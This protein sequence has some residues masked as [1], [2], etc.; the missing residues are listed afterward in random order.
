[1]DQR[2]NPEQ[3]DLARQLPSDVYYQLIHTLCAS[4]PLVSDAPDGIVSRDN[5]AIA[6]VAALQPAN[7]DE[8]NLAAT[9]VAAHA[10][11]MN[12]LR[13]ARKYAT[14][15]HV[16]AL[17]CRAQAASMLRETQATHSLLLR[18]QAVRRKREAD[19]A[20]SE[21]AART[22]RRVTGLMRQALADAAAAAE[23]QALARSKRAALFR[24][25]GLPPE[26]PILARRPLNSSGR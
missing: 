18:V 7:A 12:C 15:D 20:A 14:A 8:A 4:L 22:E 26:N 10:Q 1:M 11:A 24:A 3:P 5:A 13:L 17:K 19:S 16:L 6:H 23:E 2:P 9:L 21:A 25:L